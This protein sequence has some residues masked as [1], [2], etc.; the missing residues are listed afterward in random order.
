MRAPVQAIIVFLFFHFVTKLF[1]DAFVPLGDGTWQT[2][3]I[4][5][6]SEEILTVVA[7]VHDHF[8]RNMGQND[9]NNLFPPARFRGSAGPSFSFGCPVAAQR[10]VK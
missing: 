1:S 10:M 8:W 9:G 6:T 4:A 2:F 7:A 5:E 3:E